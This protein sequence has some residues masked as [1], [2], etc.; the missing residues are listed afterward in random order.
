[1]KILNLF[2]LI[3]VLFFAS[4]KTSR[5]INEFDSITR[6]HRVIAILP[7]QSKIM[8]KSYEKKN[9]TAEDII[10]MELAQGREVQ[11]AIESY[12]LDK[13]LSVRVQ[14][15]NTTNN[16]LEKHGVDFAN[17][18]DEDY[19]EL[20]DI[21]GV[22]AVITGYIETEKPMS[23]AVAT[24]IDIVRR[25]TDVFDR[26]GGLYINTSTNKGY[27]KLGLFDQKSATMLWSYRNEIKMYKG[28]TT[29]DIINTLMR[30]GAR[31]FPYRR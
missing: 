22:D 20:A 13:D 19:S 29:Q 30:R 4:C 6:R 28:S 1:M 23:E 11:E 10:K 17:I 9:L 31:K 8:L 16:R 18:Q 7:L 26:L 14:S 25:R 2:I 5:T 21:L 12:L 15:T 27:C 24:V 3:S